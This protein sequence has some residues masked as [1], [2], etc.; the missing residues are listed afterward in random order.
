MHPTV[1]LLSIALSSACLAPPPHA[2]TDAALPLR[3][4]A[5]GSCFQ[6]DG[7][8]EIWSTIAEYDPELL[9][10][11]GDNV[12]ADTEDMD[13]MRAKYAELDAVPAFAGLR[14]ST[15][16]LAT[17]D[18]HDYGVNDGGADY[19]MRSQAKEVFL[20]FL[21]E[22]RTSPRREREGI[23]DARV[24][25]PR[26]K[27]VQVILLDTRYFRGPLT[28]APETA[29]RFAA[30]LG[31]LGS[32]VGNTDPAATV[33]GEAQW[34]W[35]ERELEKPAE[36]RILA[37]S[38]QI[39]AEDHHFERWANFPHERKRLFKTLRR[40]G[41]NGVVAIS[42]DRHMAEISVLDASRAEPDTALDPGYAFIDVTSSSLN[43][44]STW[45]NEVNRHRVGSAYFDVNFGTL[46]LDWES[47]QLRLSIR[48]DSGQEAIR[49][50]VAFD[51]LKPH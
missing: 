46:E 15:T 42:G 7:P 12:Y 19:P 51:E 25:G 33:L 14:A 29:L 28:K 48:N 4:I 17:W 36:I 26:G 45:R 20:D 32:Y 27:R 39:V 43:R 5:F 49:F 6:S 44:P 31:R 18:D 16:L 35:L 3:R 37:S 23:Y 9:I 11:L 8:P 50:E 21:G 24:F 40:T 47:G 13:V 1:L 22:P 34:A 30:A 2:Q 10:L 41:A 38:I